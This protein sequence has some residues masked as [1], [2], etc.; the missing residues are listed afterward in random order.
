[1]LVGSADQRSKIRT[2]NIAPVWTHLLNP[3][4]VFTFG[5]FVRQDQ[6]NYYPSANPFSDLTPDL[7]S[8]TDGQ[9]RRL[10]NAGARASVSYVSGIHNI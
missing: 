5:A 4:T 8:A 2:F 7:Q 1:M 3:K 9:S 6:Y 10:T